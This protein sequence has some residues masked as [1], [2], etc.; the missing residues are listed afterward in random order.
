MNATCGG[1][2]AMTSPLAD[3]DRKSR[4]FAGAAVAM[5]LSTFIGFLVVVNAVNNQVDPWT[6]Q[7]IRSAGVEVFTVV[8]ITFWIFFPI[9]YFCFIRRSA[10]TLEYQRLLR[11]GEIERARRFSDRAP[12]PPPSKAP[13]PP[14]R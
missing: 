5:L 6:W 12:E 7:Q 11:L 10:A 9:L 8:A 2:K 3:P 13:P 1:R 4:W 14:P